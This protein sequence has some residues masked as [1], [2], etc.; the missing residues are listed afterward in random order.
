MGRNV[1]TSKLVDEIIRYGVGGTAIVGSIALPGLAHALKRPLD[2]LFKHL[3]N[4][5][6]ERQLQ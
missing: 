2:E 5:E 6:K 1:E 4:R 3:D